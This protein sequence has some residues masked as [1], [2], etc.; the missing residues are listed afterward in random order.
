MASVTRTQ[1]LLNSGTTEVIAAPGRRSR[2]GRQRDNRSGRGFPNKSF[3]P[4]VIMNAVARDRASP[5]QPVFHSHSFLLQISAFDVPRLAVG[6]GTKMMHTKKTMP[7]GMTRATTTKSHVGI[8]SCSWY[9]Y[10]MS[11]LTRE[12]GRLKGV[13]NSHPAPRAAM[14]L[15]RCQL[16]RASRWRFALLPAG[17]EQARDN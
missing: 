1:A 12:N 17:Q 11:R 2:S 15:R 3:M 8:F 14:P 13:R 4:W 5:I 10:D 6:P 7:A 16:R 9:G